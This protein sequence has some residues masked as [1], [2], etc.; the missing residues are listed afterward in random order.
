VF[1]QLK[2]YFSFNKKERNGILLLSF[3]LF[4]LILFYQFSY[5]FKT[6]TKTDFSDF[7]K[8]L[9]E[10]QYAN[11][12]PQ[13]KEKNPLFNFNPNTLNDDDWLSLGLSEGKLKV[14]RNYQ[15]SGGY[16]K[17]KEDLQRCYAFGDAFYNTIKEYVSIPEI[18]EPESKSLQLITT[19]QIIE[20]NQADSLDLI[21]VK[22]IGSFYAKQILKYRNELGGFYSYSQF[23]EIWGLE[24]LDVDKIKLL[25]TIDTLLISKI[26]I[27]SA[28]IEK[29]RHHPYLNY[30]QAKMIVNYRTQHGNFRS[31]KDIQKIRPISQEIFR[32]IAPYLQTHD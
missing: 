11:D 25:T 30:K 10:L 12:S 21:S 1:S 23:P 17:Q 13:L 2:D 29:L 3:L 9:S 18:D 19:T 8:A 31:V 5:L 32:K 24:K 14:L 16:F 26:N 20:L 6:E 15:E 27:N 22:G 28:K 7:E 4:F